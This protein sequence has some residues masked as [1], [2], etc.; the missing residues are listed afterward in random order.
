MFVSC[1]PDEDQS[2]VGALVSWSDNN[3]FVD[4][5]GYRPTSEPM[6]PFF[7]EVGSSYLPVEQSAASKLPKNGL[8]AKLATF[9]NGRVLRPVIARDD[10]AF[11][12]I[13]TD[14]IAVGWR[15]T[16]AGS[17]FLKSS[18]EHYAPIEGEAL[19]ITWGLEQTKYFTLGCDQLTIATD[20]KPL[21]KVYG[22]RTL[23]E[24]HNTRLFRLKQRSLPWYFDI[25]HVPGK[26]NLAP[27]ATSRHPS[28]NDEDDDALQDSNFE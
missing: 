18:E 12:R 8:G 9:E 2:C 15:I 7:P 11:V 17:R 3:A 6:A 14:H 23:D 28:H 19:A 10:R 13:P 1:S 5:T 24:I 22:D 16:L 21:I 25:I 27:D 26:M 4:I 20:H